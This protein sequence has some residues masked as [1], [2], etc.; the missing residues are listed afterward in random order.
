MNAG[1]H[2][3]TK[4]T[5]ALTIMGLIGSI[6]GCGDVTVRKAKVRKGSKYSYEYTEGGY[7]TGRQTFD[8]LEDYCRGLQDEELNQGCAASQRQTAWAENCNN[9]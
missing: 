3:T 6:A 5:G 4:A 7:S 1:N 2:I 9:Y 8:S